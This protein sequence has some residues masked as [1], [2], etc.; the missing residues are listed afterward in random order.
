L[1]LT[2][3]S[4]SELKLLSSHSSSVSDS[5]LWGLKGVLS[6]RGILSARPLLGV[7]AMF[8]LVGEICRGASLVAVWRSGV[9]SIISFSFSKSSVSNLT[10]GLWRGV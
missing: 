3:K 2:T 10:M 9:S 5:G 1:S 7:R 4:S 8:R 6:A